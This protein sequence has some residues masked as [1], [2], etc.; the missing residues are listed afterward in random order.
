VAYQPVAGGLHWIEPVTQRRVGRQLHVGFRYITRPGRTAYLFRSYPITR[1]RVKIV[2]VREGRVAGDGIVATYTRWCVPGPP[3]TRPR[4][5]GRYRDTVALPVAFAWRLPGRH[6]GP[7]SGVAGLSVS[8]PVSAPS[9]SLR[10]PPAPA[11]R[12]SW[13]VIAA[14]DVAECVNNVTGHP[15][16]GQHPGKGAVATGAMIRDEI[17]AGGIDGVFELGDAVYESGL[18]AEFR[19]CY[20]PTW[21]SFR[22]ITFPVPGN[23][24]Y[25]C[26]QTVPGCPTPASAY[27]EYFG[28]R[29]G[30]PGRGYYS[31]DIGPWHV[32]ALD[33]ELDADAAAAQSSAQLAWLDQDLATHPS[34][35]L[36]A[37]WH[38]PAYSND[39]LHGDDPTMQVYFRRLHDAGA[40]LVLNGHV[41]G[42]ERWAELS[43]NG[44]PEAGGTR[45]IVSGLGGANITA[46]DTGRPG[47]EVTYDANYGLLKLTF[48][49]TG[50][51]WAWLN[52]PDDTSPGVTGQLTDTGSGSCH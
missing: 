2:A 6:P 17:A 39:P 4:L 24:E 42:Y 31:F 43:A 37:I 10:V 40:D 29:A 7:G 27:F 50:Y 20:D 13:T 41:H 51:S 28:D 38:Q 25:R 5:A 8:A 21:G 26:G 35:C 15:E 1:G 36:A 33:S 12:D 34:R 11:S 19:D 9:V 49:A 22:A 47:Q 46:V 16:D 14:G 32:V 30:P 45:E 3:R 48:T 44:L 18:P 52:A 23:H